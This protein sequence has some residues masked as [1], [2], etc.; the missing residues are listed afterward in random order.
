MHIKNMKSMIAYGITGLERVN[1][2]TEKGKH[3][4]G[5]WITPKTK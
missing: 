3:V 1:S 5:L 4:Y 2:P